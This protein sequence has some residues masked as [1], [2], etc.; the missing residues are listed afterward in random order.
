MARNENNTIISIII[1]IIRMY[2]Y[3]NINNINVISS[4][5]E[6]RIMYLIMKYQ[7]INGN[8]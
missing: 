5:N 3:N 6:K 8:Q 1:S 4:Y 2:Q 7:K